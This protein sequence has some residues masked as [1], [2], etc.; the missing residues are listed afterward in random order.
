MERLEVMP[1]GAPMK[2]RP[3]FRNGAVLSYAI[4]ALALAGIATAAQAPVAVSPGGTRE[5]E[6]SFIVGRRL[7][8][9]FFPETQRRALLIPPP[10]EPYGAP[11]L[12]PGHS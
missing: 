7:T 8:Q 4:L 1:E 9:L 12:A 5:V 2:T 3:S 11:S 6:Q 10:F